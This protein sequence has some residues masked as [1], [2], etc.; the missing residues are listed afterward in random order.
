M[1]LPLVSFATHNSPFS[2]LLFNSVF[3]PRRNA[4][5]DVTFSLLI[6]P[7]ITSFICIDLLLQAAF[8]CTS[9]IFSA[10]NLQFTIF[11]PMIYLDH[12]LA[13]KRAH[14]FFTFV[15]FCKPAALHLPFCLIQIIRLHPSIVSY[16]TYVSIISQAANCT[17]CLFGISSFYVFSASTRAR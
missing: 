4:L 3:Y 1:R 15:L 13:Q 9:S 7:V 11:S 10:C 6:D 12:L 17:V 16:V 2:D 5:T 14:S 8:D